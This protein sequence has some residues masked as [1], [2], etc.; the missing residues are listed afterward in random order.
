[1]WYGK[2]K[3]TATNSLPFLSF[4]STLPPSLIANFILCCPFFESGSI[5]ASLFIKFYIIWTVWL[6]QKVL[7]SNSIRLVKHR[8]VKIYVWRSNNNATHCSCIACDERKTIQWIGKKFST[9][10]KTK[11]LIQFRF[12]HISNSM[13]RP[14]S[15]WP[16]GESKN[17]IK[18]DGVNYRKVWLR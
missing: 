2:H 18:S 12:M 5:L 8:K 14:P 11:M 16:N 15:D 13:L 4:F 3:Y 7:L 9:Q 1:M 10:R 17:S 6:Q